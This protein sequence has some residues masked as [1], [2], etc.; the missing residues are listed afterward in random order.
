M[1]RE[2]ER[3]EG[4]GGDVAFGFFGENVIKHITHFD[5]RS[6]IP[7]ELNSELPSLI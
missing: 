6:K 3:A 7:S 5:F 4:G 2:R 1:S